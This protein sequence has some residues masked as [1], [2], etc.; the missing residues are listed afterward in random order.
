MKSVRH[1]RVWR[2]FSSSARVCKVCQ[3]SLAHTHVGA[4]HKLIYVARTTIPVTMRRSGSHRYAG[5]GVPGFL[6]GGFALNTSSS[7][8]SWTALPP[9]PVGGRQE[10]SAT[11]GSSCLRTR[12]QSRES[13]PRSQAPYS[14]LIPILARAL[15]NTAYSLIQPFVRVSTSTHN[16][17]HFLA[18]RRPAKLAHKSHDRH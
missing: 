15:V 10:V 13:I 5:G 8:L 2:A 1:Q 9:A 17:A 7:P 12:T 4:P 16:S 18:C 6:N 14:L 3:Q 11:V